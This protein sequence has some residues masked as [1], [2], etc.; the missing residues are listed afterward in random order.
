MRMPMKKKQDL[1]TDLNIDDEQSIK[2]E[3]EQSADTKNEQS[4]NKDNEQS[5]IIEKDLAKTIEYNA[6]ASIEDELAATIKIEPNVNKKIVAN[7]AKIWQIALF[8]LNNTSTNLFL[9]MMGYV[10]YYAN[11]IA[12][13][14]VV[15]ISFILTGMRVFDS[16]TDP[17]VGYIIDKTNGRFGKFRPFMV[18]G[19]LF[20]AISSLLLFYVTHLVPGGFRVPFFMATYS[21]YI[22]GYTL[23]SSVVKSGQTVI[24]NDAS[25][26][27]IITF[28]DSTFIMFAHGL[29]AFYVS[30]YLIK[31]YTNFNNPRLFEEFVITVIILAGICTSLAI[32]GIWKKDN[33]AYFKIE[34]DSKKSIHLKDYFEILK[35]NKPIKMLV[36]V[37]A[38]NGFASMVY[39]NS[40]VIVM[41]Y[42]ILMHNYPLAG[43]IGIIIGFPNLGV[44]FLGIVYAR[45]HGQ[46]KA[47]ITITRLCVI[48]QIVILWMMIFWDLTKISLT[49]FNWI[50]V[51]FLVVFTLLNGCKS[52]TNNMVV[53]MIADC[54]DYEYMRSG[55]FVPGIMG[56]LFSFVDKGISSLGT[57]FVGL[58]LSFVGFSKV[59]PQ[60]DDA[61]TPTLKWLTIF[62]YCIIPIISW[63][64]TLFTLQHYKLDKK[65][66]RDLYQ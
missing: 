47:M 25:Q 18:M 21:L 12:G 58:I 9:A 32:V 46:K 22:I 35:N 57:A 45:R 59:F 20:S 41:L 54:T 13:I 6:N 42:G 4:L 61:L 30:V 38:A 7:R 15:L 8:S 24:T 1:E 26:R 2:K 40:T 66:V 63:V 36:V 17:M 11:G 31:K 14:G 28:F 56:A 65:A 44:T 50:T 23:Q 37:A 5:I 29:V 49:H 60:V 52:I 64:I 19:Y 27:P 39:G 62:F 48:F 3:N 43:L 53:P 34:L 55:Q 33:K 51:E 16:V 10:S